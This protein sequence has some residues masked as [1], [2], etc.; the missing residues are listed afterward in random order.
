MGPVSNYKCLYEREEGGDCIRKRKK[1]YE[2]RGRDW[3]D[4]APSLRLPAATRSFKGQETNFP[5]EPLDDTQP[6]SHLDFGL[7]ILILDLWT[8]DI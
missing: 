3:S 6:C 7:M 2:L 4:V 1:Q 8:P 5:L